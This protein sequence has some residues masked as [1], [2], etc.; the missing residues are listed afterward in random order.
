MQFGFNEE[1]KFQ[2][3]S[4]SFL[5]SLDLDNGFG[6]KK[7]FLIQFFFFASKM[8]PGMSTSQS[9]FI[10][11]FLYLLFGRLRLP[12]LPRRGANA[13]TRRASSAHPSS[14]KSRCRSSHFSRF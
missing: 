2:P 14:C 4:F 12:P 1:K 13:F 8:E 11:M 3:F 7:T 9:D 6:R 5:R 10:N